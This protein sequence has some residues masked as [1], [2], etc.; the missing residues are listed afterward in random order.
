VISI[1]TKKEDFL[2]SA[3]D[4]IAE[5]FINAKSVVAFT[6]AGISTESGLADFRSSKG[7]WA[8]RKPMEIASADAVK[9]NPRMVAE[10]YRDRIREYANVKP[11]NSHYILSEW[12]FSGKMPCIAT[13]NVDG[14]HATSHEIK[15]RIN[16]LHGNLDLFCS[17]CLEKYPMEKYILG[18]DA[19]FHLCDSCQGY[20]RPNVVLFGESLPNKPFTSSRSKFRKADLCFIIGTSCEVY[21]ASSLPQETY[22]NGGKVIIINKTPTKLDYMA[23]FVLNDFNASVVLGLIKT[24]VDVLTN[25][26]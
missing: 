20:V 22:D 26:K 7:L 8:G 5:F 1:V 24:K 6:G 17:S 14:L 13:Q 11:N 18:D 16:E 3:T 4:K 25:Q 12:L 2:D 15:H 9:R 10:F 19:T 21:P 23:N